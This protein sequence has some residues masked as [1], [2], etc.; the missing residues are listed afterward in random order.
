MINKIQRLP[1]TFPLNIIEAIKTRTL[2]VM[3]TKQK[4]AY[5]KESEKML[6]K[7]VILG[8]GHA[9]AKEGFPNLSVSFY[10]R[11]TAVEVLFGDIDREMP[12]VAYQVC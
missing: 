10:T 1:K 5:M 6:E 3:Q 7:K 4:E 8:N 9:F 2:F 11:A 12:N